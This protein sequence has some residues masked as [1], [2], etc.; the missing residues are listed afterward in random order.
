MV[1]GLIR[2]TL[3][4]AVAVYIVMWIRN[5]FFGRDDEN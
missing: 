2:I 4:A 1:D 5:F 3:V